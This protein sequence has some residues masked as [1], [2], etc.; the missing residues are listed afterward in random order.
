M[1]LALALER[2]EPTSDHRRSIGFLLIGVLIARIGVGLSA[3]VLADEGDA[4]PE[5]SVCAPL[6]AY[7]ADLLAIRGEAILGGATRQ[8]L[9]ATHRAVADCIDAQGLKRSTP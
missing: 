2:S 6:A 8:E 7:A 4:R 9:L 3:A 5:L 1:F